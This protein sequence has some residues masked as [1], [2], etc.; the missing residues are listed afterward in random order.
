MKLTPTAVKTAGERQARQPGP[1]VGH[2]YWPPVNNCDAL[3]RIN[4]GG[5]RDAIAARCFT[6]AADRGALSLVL[7]DVRRCI[8]RPRTKTILRKVGY[9]KERRVDPQIVVGL[10]APARPSKPT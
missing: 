6:H 2:R 1:V 4:A 3:V 8:S 9:S 5:Y 7:N 10:L